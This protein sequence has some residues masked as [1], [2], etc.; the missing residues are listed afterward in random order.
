M[1]AWLARLKQ[2]DGWAAPYDVMPGERILPKWA[3]P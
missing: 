1:Y 3:A 2:V